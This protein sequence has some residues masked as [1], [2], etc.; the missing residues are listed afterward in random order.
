MKVLKTKLA[1]ANSDA[2]RGYT[3]FSTAGAILARLF[4]LLRRVSEAYG[5]TYDIC[6]ALGTP[7]IIVDRKAI[8]LYIRA[9]RK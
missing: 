8:A 2:P 3:V 1:V 9:I 6:G 4:V 5:Y 7:A